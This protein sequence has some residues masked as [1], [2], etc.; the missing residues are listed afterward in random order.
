MGRRNRLDEIATLGV[1]ERFNTGDDPVNIILYK[2][3]D[4]SAVP[5][6]SDVCTEIASTGVFTWDYSN[7]TTPPTA[8][9]EYFYEMRSSSAMHSDKDTFGGWPDDVGVVPDVIPTDMCKV[10]A[11][12]QEPS[13]AEGVEPNRLYSGVPTTKTYAFI[14][15]R[16]Y[17]TANR[18]FFPNYQIKSS[19]DQLTGR[20]YWIFPQGATVKFHISILDINDIVT[21]PLLSTSDLNDLLP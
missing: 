10:F 9:T 21:I 20:S 3:S 8:L 2:R 5:L 18:R 7:I 6:T 19:T 13:G 14:V 1:L 12:I 17:D 15:S 4:G 11:D 16:Y